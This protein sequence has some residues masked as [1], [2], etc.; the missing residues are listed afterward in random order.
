M[1]TQPVLEVESVAASYGR[2]QVL[3][4]A[5]LAVAESEIVALVGPNGSGKST[6]L[7]VVSGILPAR[8]GT[9]RLLGQDVSRLSVGQRV[10]RGI[11]YFL[12]GGET[13][14]DLS[15]L[16]NLQVGALGL[17]GPEY[18]RRCEEVLDLFPILR[19]YARHRAGLLSGGEKQALALGIVLMRRPKLLLLDEPSAG[20]APA[21]VADM[22][23]R[24]AEIRGRYGV[25]VLLVEQNVREALKVAS[26]V[27]LLKNGVSLG[28]YP[29]VE[30]LAGD[31]LDTLFFR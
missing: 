28:S 18:R 17:P 29:P 30:L 24:V 19:K 5:S 8:Q 22:I 12:Q 1:S 25:S 31:K 2:K 23:T 15:I 13:F 7:K 16:E 21:L 9:V 3:F 14:R 27:Y 6:L 10:A 11:G 26:R 4:G 20:L